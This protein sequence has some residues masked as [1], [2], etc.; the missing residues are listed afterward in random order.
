MPPRRSERRPFRF[1][2]GGALL[3]GI[4]GLAASCVD[5]LDLND[6][7]DAFA[8]TCALL[9]RCFS[10]QYVDCAARVD[11]L[12]TTAGVGTFDT[13]LEAAASCNESCSTVHECLDF[14]G[15]CRP[16][17][18][19]CNVDV[20]CCGFS[21]GVAA[22]AGGSCCKPSGVPCSADG[23]CCPGQGPCD[24]DT[25]TCGGVTCAPKDTPCLN[26]FQCCTGRCAPTLT[27]PRCAD[28]PCPPVGFECDSDEDCCKLVCRDGKCADPPECA[29]ITETCTDDLPC[30]DPDLVCN[31]AGG[32]GEGICSE[33]SECFPSS[34]DCFSDQ[35]CCSGFCD[36]QFKLCATCAAQG[37]TC[38]AAAPCCPPLQCAGGECLP[39]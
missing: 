10:G 7:R 5:A 6:H 25:D 27:G 4:A 26:D 32:A 23:E 24:T 35:Q 17:D 30:C 9:D 19:G 2:L 29:L 20:D 18:E 16:L 21:Q 33:S 39:L 37:D 38:S 15:M 36:P 8:D 28:V 3:C 14:A 12:Y 1:F 31:K 13:W 22:C 11:S 34:S